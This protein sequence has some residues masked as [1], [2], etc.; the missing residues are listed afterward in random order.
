MIYTMYQFQFELRIEELKDNILYYS[1]LDIVKKLLQ[2][3]KCASCANSI[4]I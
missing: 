1:W 3:I 2:S 4:L